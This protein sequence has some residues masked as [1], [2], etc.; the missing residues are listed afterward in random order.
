MFDRKK[1]APIQESLLKQQRKLNRILFWL[2]VALIIQAVY[3]TV[4]FYLYDFYT[5]LMDDYLNQQYVTLT[6][7]V[8]Y[9]LELLVMLITKKKHPELAK[10]LFSGILLLSAV[11]VTLFMEIDNI[12]AYILPVVIAV[13]FYNVVYTFTV[14]VAS[15][16]LFLVFETIAS[17]RPVMPNL[18]YYDYVSRDDPVFVLDTS[19]Y[20]VNRM[21]TYVLVMAFPLLVVCV[22]SV[23]ITKSNADALLREKHMSGEKASLQKEIALG[24]EI[25]QS[26]LPDRILH[27]DCYSAYSYM[28][29]ARMVG[30]DFYDYFTVGE[31][32]LIF[33]IGDVSGKGISAS[34]FASN[35]KALIRAFAMD[36]LAPEEIISKTNA[37]LIDTNRK[38][39]FVTV[40]LGVL[41]LKTGE[42]S[43]C[44]AGHNP[45]L[46]KKA[47]GEVACLRTK[48]NFVMGRR[49]VEYR[50]ESILLQPGDTLVL[51]TDGV[52]EAM[53]TRG[54][55]FGEERLLE[56]VRE[57]P[58]N[59]RIT[60]DLR[61]QIFAHKG[62]AEQSDD[63]S[64]ACLL[65][66]Q[67]KREE[68]SNPEDN[69]GKP[70]TGEENS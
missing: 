2:N 63:I 67:K 24:N 65:F 61:K 36:C 18:F 62:T 42:M 3:F 52:T 34:L 32:R 33:V 68:I 59:D 45:P 8:L 60:K 30:G 21:T 14:S 55:L 5:L 70:V 49:A 40:W 9:A 29:S 26:M 69:D 15:F 51:Y 31:D 58:V 17:F 57:H 46:I 53:N 11:R 37:A 6:F 64:V 66:K 13:G 43:F 25:Q 10:W 4:S 20:A 28:V 19:S 23:V 41:D 54:E 47:D 16:V 39:L 35:T 1:Y 7:A 56:Y 44:N 38:K 50:V 22:V 48:P 12:T 27:S